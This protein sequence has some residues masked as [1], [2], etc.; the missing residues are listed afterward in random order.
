MR[1]LLLLSLVLASTLAGGT[2][3]AQG[4]PGAPFD[5][6]CLFGPIVIAEPTGDPA[7]GPEHVSLA[8]PCPVF[9]GAV[10]LLEGPVPDPRDPHFWSDVAV[11][12]QPG[13]PPNPGSPAILLTFVSD[14]EPTGGGSSFGITDADFL[15]AGLPF[16]VGLVAT[17]PSTIFIVESTTSDQNF[18]HADGPFGSAQYILISDPPEQP[19]SVGAKTW[20]RVK[21]LYR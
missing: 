8:L 5:P 3:F 16:P 20:A 17:S 14:T 2:A 13:T 7:G 10:V 12:N 15:A 11:F 18:Y 9:A 6:A 19:V 1:F 21:E 4:T